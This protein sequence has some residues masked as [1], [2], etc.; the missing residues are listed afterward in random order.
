VGEKPGTIPPPTEQTRRTASPG[1]ATTD[2]SWAEVFVVSDGTGET[3]ADTVR[4]AMLQFHA[5]WRM[6]TFPDVRS[7]AQA[8]NV[9]E[10]AARNKALVVFTVVNREAAQVLRDHG[11]AND[12][13]CVDLLGPL[14]SNIAE[15]LKAEP[16]LEPGLLHGFSD[17]YFKR[18]EAVEFAVRH[19][20]GANLHTLHGADIVLTGISRTSKTPLSMYLA[21]RGYKTGNVPLIAGVDPPRELLELNPRK[22]VGLVGDIDDLSAMRRARARS[23]GGTPFQ[24]YANTEAIGDELQSAMR[25]FRSRG[26]RWI[27]ISGRAVEENASKILEI[28]ESLAQR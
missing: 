22:V 16:R 11:A 24:N 27:D 5:K 6:R 26:W 7:A 10:A 15:H 21:Q 28:I 1:A 23:L 19:D 14:I 9:I 3:A 8:R 12:V 4:A 20:D 13:P 18:I 25:L 17:S 2:D